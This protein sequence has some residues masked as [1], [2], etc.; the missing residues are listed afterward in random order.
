MIA[1]ARIRVERVARVKIESAAIITIS[2]TMRL[3]RLPVCSPS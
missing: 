2:I 3:A 1:S